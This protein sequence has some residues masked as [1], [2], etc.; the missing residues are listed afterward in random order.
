MNCAFMSK[1]NDKKNIN[2]KRHNNLRKLIKRKTDYQKKIC[3]QLTTIH[4]RLKEN[5]NNKIHIFPY[6]VHNNIRKKK[7]LR[8]MLKISNYSTTDMRVCVR[9][10]VRKNSNSLME[11][12]VI[13]SKLLNK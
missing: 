12:N 11:L 10:L 1:N 6:L 9:T 7:I 5:Y 2:F 3:C 13:F 8:K 4:H